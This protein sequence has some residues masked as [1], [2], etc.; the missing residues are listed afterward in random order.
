MSLPHFTNLTR[1]KEQ[2]ETNFSDVKK[3]VYR[4]IKLQKI[5]FIINNGLVKKD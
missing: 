4:K 3:R 1:H 2:W 5:K